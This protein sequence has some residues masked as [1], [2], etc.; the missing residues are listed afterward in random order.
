MAILK[1]TL[2]LLLRRFLYKLSSSAL[3][4][5]QQ[6]LILAYSSQNKVVQYY[7]VIGD[8][9]LKRILTWSS[10]DYQFTNLT[11]C[12]GVNSA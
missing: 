9:S 3:S 4:D 2:R 1:P 11:Y 5:I 12:R 7:F 8:F 10:F 6:F